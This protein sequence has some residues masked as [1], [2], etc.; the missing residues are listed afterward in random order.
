MLHSIEKWTGWDL[1]HPLYHAKIAIFQ[2]ICRPADS[3]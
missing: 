1:T 2:L 3:Q